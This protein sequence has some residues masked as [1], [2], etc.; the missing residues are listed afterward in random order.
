MLTNSA[1]IFLSLEDLWAGLAVASD[2]ALL[3]RIRN[4]RVRTQ[5]PHTHTRLKKEN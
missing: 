1:F 5:A 2:P 3:A 4:G